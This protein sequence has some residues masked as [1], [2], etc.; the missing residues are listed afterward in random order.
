MENKPFISILAVATTIV[1]T[2]IIFDRCQERKVVVPIPV[3]IQAVIDSVKSAE[4][5]LQPK[6]DSLNTVIGNAHV[7]D[8]SDKI[9]MAMLQAKNR[10][11][12]KQLEAHIDSMGL[13]EPPDSN[14]T[15]PDNDYN[16][17]V[18]EIIANC[19]A[20][21][22]IANVRIN[23]LDA[24]LE[25]SRQIII[26][27]DSLYNVT[28]RAFEASVSQQINLNE[29]ILGLQKKVKKRGTWNKILGGAALIGAG[30]I[31]NYAIK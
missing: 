18:R 13:Y 7:K 6:I 21:D 5:K 30:F 1:V 14:W 9:T 12:A 27:K 17:N 29:T 26:Q 22:S 24:T 3:D 4:F 8:S 15:E 10:S 2:A 28:K 19:A 11:L 16:G 20:S 31:L 23:N 25:N